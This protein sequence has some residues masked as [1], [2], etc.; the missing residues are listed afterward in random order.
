MYQQIKR[1]YGKK[2]NATDGY[3][4]RVRD[5]LFDES[6]W[7]LRYLVADTGSWLPKRLVLF[8]LPAFATPFFGKATP[9]SD[10]L[11]VNLT[12]A[13][14]EASPPLE[15]S[16]SVSRQFEEDYYRYYGWPAYWQD[17]GMLGPI[18]FPPVDP[19]PAPEKTIQK[20]LAP[21]EDVLLRSTNTITGYNIQ[22]TDGPLGVV[23]DFIANS[24]DWTVREVVVQT[25][26]WLSRKEILILP[27]NIERISHKE[28]LVFINL[29]RENLRQTTSHDVAQASAGRR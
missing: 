12:R 2:L 5:F 28:P 18:G 4:G 25:G 20:P 3:I 9:T 24:K 29:A 11:T 10:L 8:P 6:T 1:L 21:N 16:R 7:T 23:S 17:N 27:E 15:S 19:L 26:H 22:T 13:K 14:I